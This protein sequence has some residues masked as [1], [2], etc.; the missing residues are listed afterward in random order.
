MPYFVENTGVSRRKLLIFNSKYFVKDQGV[1]K[2]DS[3]ALQLMN[4]DEI[5]QKMTNLHIMNFLLGTLTIAPLCLCL[6]SASG[7]LA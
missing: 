7:S 6:P 5:S 1:K 3:P 2:E 4:N